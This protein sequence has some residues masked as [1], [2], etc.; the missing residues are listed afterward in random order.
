MALQSGS[1]RAAR[2][3]GRAPASSLALS[4]LLA[5]VGIYQKASRAVAPPIGDAWSYYLKGEFC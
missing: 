4:L 1:G 3:W 2:F 5:G